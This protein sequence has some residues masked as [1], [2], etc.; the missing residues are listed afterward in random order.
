MVNCYVV[1]T[2]LFFYTVLV[3]DACHLTTAQA[4]ETED[5]LEVRINM[6][7]LIRPLG[8]YYENGIS[9]QSDDFRSIVPGPSLTRLARLIK[10][11]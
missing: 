8:K 10:L 1:F 7:V 3:S 5:K 4:K 11:D 6:A 9:S 2:L